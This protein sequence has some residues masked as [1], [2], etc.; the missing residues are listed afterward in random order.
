MSTI[1]PISLVSQVLFSISS[2]LFHL[3][4]LFIDM[5]KSSLP[6][7]HITHSLYLWSP[8]LLY[9]RIQILY[10][11]WVN[12]QPCHNTVIPSLSPLIALCIYLTL[13][14]LSLP[15]LSLCV[16]SIFIRQWVTLCHV[17]NMIFT[18]HEAL[19]YLKLKINLIQLE[20]IMVVSISFFALSL[21]IQIWKVKSFVYRDIVQTLILCPN[22]T[23]TPSAPWVLICLDRARWS[24]GLSL[25]PGSQPH[26]LNACS[27]NVYWKGMGMLPY[28]RHGEAQHLQDTAGRS[29]CKLSWLDL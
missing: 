29:T 20:G 2:V 17:Y 22:H 24:R 16:I 14:L 15:K 7:S 3:I 4:P 1:F 10:V 19:F 12:S 13:Y 5:P 8:W 27:V 28:Q 25:T 6:H 21:C 9:S 11:L 18:L 26:S 23:S